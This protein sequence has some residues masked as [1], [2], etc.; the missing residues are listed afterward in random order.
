MPHDPA[1]HLPLGPTTTIAR[2]LGEAHDDEPG[3]N[4]KTGRV[5]GTVISLEPADGAILFGV[6][7]GTG[8]LTV[9][10]RHAH[11]I[12]APKIDALIEADVVLTPD[13]H[14]DA[15]VLR[16]SPDWD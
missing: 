8:L 2:F 15:T 5:R 14:I 7:D 13:G 3:W 16:R 10:S 9:T 6:D 12:V 1:L 11:E 4:T